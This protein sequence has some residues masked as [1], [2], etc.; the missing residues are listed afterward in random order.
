MGGCG[1]G[2]FGGVEA[3]EAKDGVVVWVIMDGG[4]GGNPCGYTPQVGIRM[5]ESNWHCRQLTLFLFVSAGDNPCGYTPQV[6]IRM[7]ESSWH[8]RQLNQWRRTP[9]P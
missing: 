4:L 6:G 7:H 1:N 8:C 5:H 3:E 9:H 2:L